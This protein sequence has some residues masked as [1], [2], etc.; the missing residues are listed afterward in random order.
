MSKTG[1]LRRE[2][3]CATVV[4][5]ENLKDIFKVNMKACDE[6]ENDKEWMLSEVF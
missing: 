5:D 4:E 1:E 6:I 2:D 3:T